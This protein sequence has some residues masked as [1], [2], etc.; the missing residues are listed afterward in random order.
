MIGKVDDD[1]DDIKMFIQC[2]HVFMVN[3]KEGT[4]PLVIISTKMI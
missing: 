4:A 1:D 3:I 2:F